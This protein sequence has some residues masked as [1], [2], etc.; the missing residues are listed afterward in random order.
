MENLAGRS[1][2]PQRGKRAA[3]KELRAIYG[4]GDDTLTG[5][6]GADKLNGGAG[7]DSL[8]GGLGNDTLTGGAG[9]DSFHFEAGFGRDVITDFVEGAGLGDVVEFAPGLFADFN[10]M[11]GNAA[12]VTRFVGTTKATDVVITYDADPNDPTNPVDTL[13][14]QNTTKLTLQMDD[15]RF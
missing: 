10:A 12:E 9:N 15:F 2:S 7:Q 5:G 11:L 13:M 3:H 14:I 8:I 4:A 6:A 1:G